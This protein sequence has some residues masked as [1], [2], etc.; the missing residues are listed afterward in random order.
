MKIMTIRK[1]AFWS[2][3]VGWGH[4][5]LLNLMMRKLLLEIIIMIL[6]ETHRRPNNSRKIIK[7]SFEIIHKTS[8]NGSPEK[9]KIRGV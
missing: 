3:F 6:R 5:S 4:I 9:S 8:G 7:Y 1:L 2:F